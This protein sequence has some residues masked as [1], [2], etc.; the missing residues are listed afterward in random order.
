MFRQVGARRRTVLVAAGMA[1]VIGL[2]GCASNPGQAG[3][4]DGGAPVGAGTGRSAPAAGSSEGTS[5]GGLWKAAGCVIGGI[6]GAAAGK[7]AAGDAK[8]SRLSK[9]EQA[10]RERSYLIAGALLGCGGG[11]V[12][13]GTV[14][15]KLSEAGRR[16][17]EKAL[18]AAASQA[19]PQRYGEPGNP[20]LKGGVVPGKRYA[21]IAE[22]RECM[23]VEDTLADGSSKDSIFVKMC[24]NLP[25]GGWAPVTA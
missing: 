25:N 5:E 9:T 11:A 13:S 6:A 3:A 18:I 24:R 7:L 20:T 17:R 10:K 14:Y 8:K 19:R 4:I 2:Q 23:D 16:E 15:E 1:V 21:E 22:K 12:L